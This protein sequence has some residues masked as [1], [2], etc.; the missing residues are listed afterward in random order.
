M[1]SL[2]GLEGES[3]GQK[4]EVEILKRLAG[5]G[6]LIFSMPSSPL[7]LPADM[8][9]FHVGIGKHQDIPGRCHITIGP[10]MMPTGRLPQI[11][12]DVYLEW[13]LGQTTQPKAARGA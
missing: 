8:A 5:H 1:R 9:L 12:A 4:E 10:E 2:L 11:V 7:D 13:S 3:N 6:N